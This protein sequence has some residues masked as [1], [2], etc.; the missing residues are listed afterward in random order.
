MNYTLVS[1]GSRLPST[2]MATAGRAFGPTR[3]APG[4]ITIVVKPVLFNMLILECLCLQELLAPF[5][6][7]SSLLLSDL[8]SLSKERV[9][10]DMLTVGLL[11]SHSDIYVV[12]RYVVFLCLIWY[13]KPVVVVWLLQCI[14]VLHF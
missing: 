10:N 7:N 14:Y 8:K 13:I 6:S 3:A 2:C 11:S 5:Y 9:F 4:V 12:H 1:S